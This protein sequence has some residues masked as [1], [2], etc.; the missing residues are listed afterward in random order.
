MLGNRDPEI[1]NRE[2]VVEKLT[3]CWRRKPSKHTKQH[4]AA[5]HRA[6]PAG[7]IDYRLNTVKRA[8][9]LRRLTR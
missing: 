2:A 3:V 5:S 7:V 8:S 6:S 9:C 4:R 1:E